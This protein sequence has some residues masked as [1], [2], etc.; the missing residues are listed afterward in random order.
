M[1]NAYRL[2]ALILA[3]GLAFA[4]LCIGIGIYKGRAVDRYVTV[5]GLAE[6]EVKAD[7]A[8][9]PITFRVTT[10]DLA[11]LRTG[12]DQGRAEVTQFL[13]DAGFPQEVIAYSV[14]R[15][16]DT[17]A[18]ASNVRTLYRYVADVSVTTRSNDVDLVKK[19]MEQSGKLVGKGVVLSADNWQT[20]TEFLFTNLNT[21]K[22][23][24][25]EEA[26]KD[27]RKAAEK[28]A[29]DSGS[30]VGKIRGATQGYFSISDRDRN[31]PEMKVIRVVTTVEYF[32]V[33]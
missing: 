28:F 32:L 25:I 10:N 15:I 13:K 12:I 8:I 23:A 26:T 20:P 1:T 7:L 22:P 5:K 4:G 3:L 2:P 21:I 18:F 9:W 11:A 31:S 6:R 24:M 27:A 19:T 16:N 17:Q 14:P 33:D 29:T 30:E